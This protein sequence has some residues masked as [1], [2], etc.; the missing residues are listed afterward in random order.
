M[1][2]FGIKKLMKMYWKNKI[3]LIIICVI[4]IALGIRYIKVKEPKYESTTQILFAKT[5]EKEEE[6]TETEKK[7]KTTTSK[8]TTNTQIT[9]E[10]EDNSSKNREN[11]EFSE[12]L[13]DTYMDLIKSDVVI[14]K[15]VERI[16]T[17]ETI[18]KNQI[19]NNLEISRTSDDAAILEIKAVNASPTMAQS[20]S[21]NVSDVFLETI[22]EYYEMENAY[23]ITEAKEASE[24]YNINNKL[25]L[26]VFFV[27]GFA[28]AS[29]I[30]LVKTMYQNEE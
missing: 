22:Q 16:G 9:A 25:D 5:I 12:M 19:V 28:L 18:E 29:L 1:N 20:I 26:I 30:I 4:S 17:E 10:V 23:I 21:K 14:N 8:N 24:P 7:S 13:M 11:L 3:I 15:V 6:T 27:A 2:E